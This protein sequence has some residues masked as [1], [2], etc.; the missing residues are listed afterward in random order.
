M[1]LAL[2]AEARLEKLLS[3]LE[4]Q[5]LLSSD[6]AMLEENGPSEIRSVADIIATSLVR[7]EKG[8][9]R[10]KQGRFARA[11][12]SIHSLHARPI[13]PAGLSVAFSGDE[14]AEEIEG[15]E[16]RPGGDAL[17]KRGKRK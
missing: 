1:K 10:S 15:T 17:S 13:G 16:D 8:A 3:E 9:S 6:A 5:V 11:K 2:N 14:E 4:T 7:R 12:R